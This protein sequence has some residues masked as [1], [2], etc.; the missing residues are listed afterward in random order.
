MT[1]TK[2]AGGT[3]DELISWLLCK[4]AMSSRS[5]V[6]HSYLIIMIIMKA[7]IKRPYTKEV[8]QR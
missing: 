8:P 6:E 3:T 1:S 4:Q 5:I 7:F 2:S